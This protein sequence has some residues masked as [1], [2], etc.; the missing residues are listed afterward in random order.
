[1]KS[2]TNVPKGNGKKLDDNALESVAGGAAAPLQKAKTG[3][4]TG[5]GVTIPVIKK[6]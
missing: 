4:G 3:G 5:V 2:R 6:P 1:M